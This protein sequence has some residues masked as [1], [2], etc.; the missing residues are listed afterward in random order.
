[1]KPVASFLCGLLFSVG[2]IIS[3]MINPA[4]VLAFLDVAGEWDPSLGFVMG[5]AV[6]VTFIGYR[7]VLKRQTPLFDTKFQV[8][9]SR[10]IDAPLIIG[11]ATFGVGWGIVGLCPGPAVTVVSAAVFGQAQSMTIVFFMALLAGFY[12]ARTYKRRSAAVSAT[13]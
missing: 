10:Q 11:A 4:R 9:I 3:D 1:M 13:Q 2:L 5:G 7:W 12:I 8:P 6:L